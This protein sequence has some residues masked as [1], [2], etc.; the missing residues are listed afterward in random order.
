MLDKITGYAKL[1]P[2]DAEVQEFVAL[3]AAGSDKD[4][5]AAAYAAISAALYKF[6][7]QLSAAWFYLRL[8]NP[9]TGSRLYGLLLLGLLPSRRRPP[10]EPDSRIVRPPH[11]RGAF[12]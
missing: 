3:C 11:R 6:M 5:L 7:P 1:P 2:G 4:S 12:S 10:Y 8:R 9:V